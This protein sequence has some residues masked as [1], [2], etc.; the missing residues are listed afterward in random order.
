[1]SE[2]KMNLKS[3]KTNEELIDTLSIEFFA[4]CPKC[5]TEI[6]VPPKGRRDVTCPDCNET[7]KP[8]ALGVRKKSSTRKKNPSFRDE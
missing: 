2:K 3:P 8:I 6:I 4:K 5:G 7:F 1:M